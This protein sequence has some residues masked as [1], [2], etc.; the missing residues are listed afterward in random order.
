VTEE[1]FEQHRRHRYPA[2]EYF[3][4]P[5]HPSELLISAAHY[6]SFGEIV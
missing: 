3:R 4:K 1:V 5:V 2:D 6:V